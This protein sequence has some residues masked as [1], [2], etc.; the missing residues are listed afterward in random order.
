MISRE[1]SLLFTGVEVTPAAQAA[2]R[3]LGP[4]SFTRLTSYFPLFL[5]VSATIQRPRRTQFEI[6]AQL[7]GIASQ[8]GATKTS[9]VYKA[10]LNFKLAQ[11]YLDELESKGMIVR[12]D[13]EL[14]TIYTCT[15]RGREALR[16]ISQTLDFMSEDQTSQ[17]DAPV[18]AF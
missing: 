7:L 16:N 18:Q 11:R 4:F 15:E 13:G 14:G 17:S 5:V 6:V 2:F 9:L 12:R 8:G 10:N 3:N 1:E